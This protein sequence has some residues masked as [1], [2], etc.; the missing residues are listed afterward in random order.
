[1]PQ[2]LFRLQFDKVPGV[3]TH[4]L[5]RGSVH[6]R[7]LSVPGSPSVMVGREGHW[8]LTLA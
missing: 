6:C 3:Y 2:M 1:M 4:T 8:G 5:L 7:N